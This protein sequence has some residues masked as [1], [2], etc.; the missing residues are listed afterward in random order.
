[1]AAEWVMAP[2]E[3]R[4]LWL[5]RLGRRGTFPS[6]R[7]FPTDSRR[8]LGKYPAHHRALSRPPPGYRVLLAPDYE[9]VWFDEALLEV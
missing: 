8:T 3:R 7:F 6:G 2:G 9:D 1:M 4:R 5:V